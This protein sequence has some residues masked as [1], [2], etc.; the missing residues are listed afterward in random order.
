MGDM[1]SEKP[2]IL[3][4]GPSAVGKSCILDDFKKYCSF[5][6]FHIDTS[7]DRSFEA[8][9]FPPDWDQDY[10]LLDFEKIECKVNKML[11]KYAGA[12]ISFPTSYVLSL[13]ELA[14]ASEY[15]ISPIILWSTKEQCIEAC[16]ERR[17]KKSIPFDLR[18]YE[19]KNDPTFETY[20]RAEYAKFR[21]EAFKPDGSRFQID[22]LLA[23]IMKR[24]DV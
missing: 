20:S 22:K 9:G 19:K 21:V 11:N 15:G 14:K 8:N 24:I 2:I 7:K 4:L 3:I 16:K 17:R 5:L 12:V 18:D 6:S 1:E 23:Q 13:E 10:K